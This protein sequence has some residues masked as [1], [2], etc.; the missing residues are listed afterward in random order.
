MRRFAI[1]V[2]VDGI[3]LYHRIHG[4]QEPAGDADAAWAVGVPRFLDLFEAWGVRGTFFAVAQDLERPEAR[5]VAEELVARGH[6]LASH[7]YSHPYDLIHR[8]AVELEAELARAEPVLEAIRGAPVA[9]FRAPGYNISAP[10]RALLVARGYTYDS[11]VFPCP[12]YYAARAGVIGA[13]RLVGRRSQSIVGNV[14]DAF[15][16]TTPWVRPEG[17]VDLP[18]SVLPGVRF[19]LIGT[20]LT[21]LGASL[22]TAMAPALRSLDFANVELHAIDL[23]DDLD[24]P[25]P[26]LR[27]AQP[28]L[29]VPWR[30]KLAAFDALL[31]ALA[32]GAE[33]RTLEEHAVAMRAVRH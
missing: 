26:A 27:R 13:L 4:L 20:S 15:T 22:I 28:D 2:D 18:I 19:P 9:G 24:V 29:R 3:A 6:E 33:C 12:P 8:N 14:G 11:S 7:S 30:T 10:L 23:L 5:R 32:P 31:R 21:L 16:R 25:L 17:L 1:T